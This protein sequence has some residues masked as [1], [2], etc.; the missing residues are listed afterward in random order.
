MGRIEVGF[1]GQQYTICGDRMN[2]AL[3]NVT[4]AVKGFRYCFFYLYNFSLT[5]KIPLPQAF[6]ILTKYSFIMIYELG[7]FFQKLARG[8]SFYRIS[9][10][11]TYIQTEKGP[12]EPACNIDI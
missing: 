4:C 6:N 3:A 9:V 5:N 8:L 11:N 2:M 7:F 1:Y 10:Y 12:S